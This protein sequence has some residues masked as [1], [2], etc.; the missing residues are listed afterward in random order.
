PPPG[1]RA[2]EPGSRALT[3][4]LALPVTSTL[5]GAGP[6]M[7]RSFTAATPRASVVTVSVVTRVRAVSF[8][9]SV[10]GPGVW[11]DVMANTT[12][13]PGSPT[14]PTSTLKES[15]TESGGTAERCTVSTIGPAARSES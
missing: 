13:R 5:A 4:R 11:G 15:E 6:A 9:T 3:P 14:V 8:V 10:T 12:G 1:K 2:G 7:R